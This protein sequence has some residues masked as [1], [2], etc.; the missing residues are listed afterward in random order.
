MTEPPRRKTPTQEEAVR[1]I[2]RVAQAGRG[3]TKWSRQVTDPHVAVFG[4]LF[5]EVYHGDDPNVLRPPVK[6]VQWVGV[7]FPNNGDKLDFWIP[8][9]IDPADL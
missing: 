6:R 1:Q 4:D 7:A 9:N 5:A 3:Q 8:L 2:G